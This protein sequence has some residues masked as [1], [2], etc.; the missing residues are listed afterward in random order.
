MSSICGICRT[1]GQPVDSHEIQA[2]L[3]ALAH[4][5][6]DARGA[7]SRAEVGLGHLRL[8]VTPESARE[9]QPFHDVSA[10]HAITADLRIDNRAELAVQLGIGAAELRELP[11]SLLVLRAYQRW[12]EAC[13]DHLLGDFAFAI[14]D[15]GRR[16]LFCARDPI[17]VRPFYYCNGTG[18]FTFGSEMKALLALPFVDRTPDE[19]WIADFLQRT[20]LDAEATFYASIR[21]L[22]PAHLIVVS[23]EGL[24]TRRYWQPDVGRELRLARDED[25][26]EGFREKLDVAVRRRLRTNFVV[27]AELSGGLDSAGLCAM[28]QRLLREQGRQLQTFSQVRPDAASGE[29][30]PRDSRREIELVLR[31]AGIAQSSFVTDGNAGMLQSLEWADRYFDEPPSWIVS[32]FND[33]L[34]E[35]ATAKGV[36]VL[37]SGFGGNQAVTS[38][39][40]GLQEELLLAGRWPEL[41]RELA[42]ES[43]S[44]V[45]V[46]ALTVLLARHL[47]AR[48][49]LDEE[50]D[51]PFWQKFEHR[52]LREELRTSLG[53]RQRAKRFREHY[54]HR[55]SLRDRAAGML[56]T[57]NVPFRLEYANLST[58]AR[59]I[60]YVYPLLDLELIA[61]YMAVPS[62]LK[63]QRGI[64]RFL[65]RQSME[66]QLPDDIRWSTA[67]RTSANPG[68]AVRKRRDRDELRER[69]AAVPPDSPLFHYVDQARMTSTPSI[70]RSGATHRW[71]RDTELLNV[72][73]LEQKLRAAAG[74]ESKA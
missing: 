2:M 58:A 12:G 16:R 67:P 60:Q 34:Y 50:G 3:T 61:F 31:H 14:W 38:E 43:G 63:R 21:R 46:A 72:L 74:R 59:R 24:R 26:V 48:L 32:L 30:L 28:S 70:R 69:L 40:V 23:A 11:D 20:M 25:Y 33:L 64:G 19:Q 45:P 62:R 53:M 6:P 71:E 49:G 37:I 35:D 56:G 55:G 17:G 22:L 27:G 8:T 47:A 52:P 9:A 1:E 51:L 42:A 66:G 57:P 68:A 5:E 13:V 54:T 4:W 15:G 73:M 7:W 36:R 39:G 41:W 44:R 29:P 18:G 65:F 10:D